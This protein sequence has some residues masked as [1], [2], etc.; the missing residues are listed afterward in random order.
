MKKIKILLIIT[1]ASLS[2]YA[3]NPQL[4]ENTWYLQKVVVNDIVFLPPIN[5]EVDY[6]DL[7]IE[8]SNLFSNVCYTIIGA[9]EEID[10]ENLYVSLFFFWDGDCFL[11]ET[12]DFEAVYFA[13]F[14]MA[15]NSNITISYLIEDESNNKKLTLT[16]INGDKAIYGNVLLAQQDFSISNITIYPNPIK[17]TLQ[18]NNQNAIKINNLQMYD[19]MGRL[20]LEE[21]N[22]RMQLDVSELANGLFFVRLETDQGI[23]VRKVIKQ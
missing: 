4:F 17:N 9:I 15:E 6:V 20:V 14:F 3:Q 8:E 12:I 11:Q 7:L 1:F 22:P 21:V 5:D 19:L 13:G 23:F 18:I 2:S 10:N 16:N